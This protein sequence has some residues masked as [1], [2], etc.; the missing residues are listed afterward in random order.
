LGV[1]RDQPDR[2][3][4]LLPAH[5]W[6]WAKT[7][8]PPPG[9]AP[10]ELFYEG[11]NTDGPRVA[12]CWRATRFADGDRLLPS[13]SIDEVVEVPFWEAIE[14]LAARLGDDRTIMRLARNRVTVEPT[15]IAGIRPGDTVI[16]AVED[17]LY[18][19]HGWSPDGDTEVLDVS[20]GGWP[21]FPLDVAT[22]R[23][24]ISGDET[25]ESL[26]P[27]IKE[28]DEED[29]EEDQI[30]EDLLAELRQV[31]PRP[32]ISEE[33]SSVLNELSPT[34]TWVGSV[35]VLERASTPGPRRT[36]ILLAADGFDDLSADV[37][38]VGLDAHL[39]SVGELAQRLGVTVGLPEELVAAV[40]A[41]GRFHDLGKA[42]Q[43]FQR[44]LDPRQKSD[45]PLAKS[46]T[47]RTRWRADRSASGWPARGR[48][49]ALSARMVERW[50][51]GQGEVAWDRDL[52]THLV[53]S[54]HGYG[55]PLV[56]PV[57]DDA[58]VAVEYVV[59]G[60]TVTVSGD[61]D[62]ADWDQPARF[63]RCCERYGY[64]GLAL[65]EAVVR[66]ADHLASG[67]AG[68]SQVGVA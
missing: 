62:E 12:I 9:E 51:D 41:A 32:E 60:R 15:A 38:D 19:Q 65:L 30:A 49:E 6:E 27:L 24:W 45:R 47:S 40:E 67:L 14:T 5:L 58:S 37:T 63:H 43:R 39:D 44:W 56:P 3:A 26:I 52:V 31:Q 46:A 64:W 4:E 55:R 22:L 50:L 13:V 16:L 35:P 10:V 36:S 48:H 8:T 20:L 1:P 28:L 54:H 53:I 11:F 42:D 34:I 29:F 2:V 59:A 23:H 61:L 68:K 33:W 21:G 18:D 66:Q 17:G 25:L 7:T 57:G